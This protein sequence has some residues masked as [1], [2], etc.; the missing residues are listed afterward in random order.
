[1][2]DFAVGTWNLNHTENFDEYMKAVGVGMVMRKLG[3][4]LRPTQEISVDGDTWDIK[5][6]TTFK[7]SELKFTL[8]E[9]FEE[10]TVDGRKVTTTVRLEGQKLIQDQ[11][12]NPDSLITRE[13]DGSKMTM[14]LTA[15]GV[16]CTRIY[17]KQGAEGASS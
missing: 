6:I 13:F 5:T 16:S 17:H 10:T 7:S 8:N 11:K 12:G 15:K 1:M 14:T 2:A 3:G 4:T 9:P